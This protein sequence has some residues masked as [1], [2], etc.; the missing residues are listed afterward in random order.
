[1]IGSRRGWESLRRLNGISWS[2]SLGRSS[3]WMRSNTLAVGSPAGLRMNCH[4]AWTAVTVLEGYGYRG[5]DA[6]AITHP[7]A[8]PIP[9]P[10]GTP[11]KRPN[12]TGPQQGSLP[13]GVTTPTTKPVP[14]PTSAPQP[15][16][17]RRHQWRLS[18]PPG[19]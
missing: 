11:N 19:V 1:V 8:A 15:I 4:P 17:C 12:V 6:V 5:F 9:A 2:L 18:A 3:H 16:G 14:N 10:M 7:A 13:C